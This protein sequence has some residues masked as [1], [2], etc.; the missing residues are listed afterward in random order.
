[1]LKYSR[2]KK[3]VILISGIIHIPR[4]WMDESVSHM[5]TLLYTVNASSKFRSI[6]KCSDEVCQKLKYKKPRDISSSDPTMKTMSLID[7]SCFYVAFLYTPC[8]C[9]ALLW[10]VPQSKIMHIR[11]MLEAHWRP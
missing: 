7:S 9:V 11:S 2:G 10:V 1:M 5:V 3:G 6:Q 8:G 4:Y